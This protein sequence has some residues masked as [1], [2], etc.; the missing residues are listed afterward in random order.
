MEKFDLIIFY[1]ALIYLFS[2]RIL[3][4][5]FLIV[6]LQKIIISF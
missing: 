5:V 4:T 3:M 2:F 1:I 6:I